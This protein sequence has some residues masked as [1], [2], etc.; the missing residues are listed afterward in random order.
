MNEHLQIKKFHVFL[1]CVPSNITQTAVMTQ[2]IQ[3]T[4]TMKA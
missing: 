4:Y 3:L 1:W 2:K